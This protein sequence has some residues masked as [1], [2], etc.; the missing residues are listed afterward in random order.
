MLLDEGEHASMSINFDYGMRST[1]TWAMN[2]DGAADWEIEAA[3]GGTGLS[4][5]R[6]TVEDMAPPNVTQIY[7]EAHIKASSF[8]HGTVLQEAIRKAEQDVHWAQCGHPNL[9]IPADNAQH[10]ALPTSN[11]FTLLEDRND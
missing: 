9:V 5:G 3:M 11:R 8:Q 6:A 7:P 10:I 2:T 4:T 1:Q